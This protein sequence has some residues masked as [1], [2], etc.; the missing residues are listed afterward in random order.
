MAI[1]IISKNS[2]GH[3]IVVEKSSIGPQFWVCP[4]DLA[5]GRDQKRSVH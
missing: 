1:K 3:Q 2:I 5:K 4:N